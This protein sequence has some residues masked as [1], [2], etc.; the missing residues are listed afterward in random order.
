[1]PKPKK[2]K[3]LRYLY[4]V[5]RKLPVTEYLCLE[6]YREAK[7][8]ADEQTKK[9]LNCRQ[10]S[11]LVQNIK[12][13]HKDVLPEQR[14]NGSEIFCP[15]K[16][17]WLARAECLDQYTDANAFDRAKS[18]CYRCVRG[19]NLRAAEAALVVGIVR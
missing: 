13:R 14:A 12:D 17:C 19:V 1:M 7:V 11:F 18:L 15:A 9:C 2:R 8:S 10:G 16:S 6:R 4:C 3:K 5:K